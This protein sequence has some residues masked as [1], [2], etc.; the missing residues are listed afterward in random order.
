MVQ[1]AA[2]FKQE[3]MPICKLNTGKVHLKYQMAQREPDDA[4]YSSKGVQLNKFVGRTPAGTG[5]FQIHSLSHL[6][7]GENHLVCE[8][9]KDVVTIGKCLHFRTIRCIKDNA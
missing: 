9:N 1:S 2:F 6:S 7:K 5:K 3:L 8:T 4:F